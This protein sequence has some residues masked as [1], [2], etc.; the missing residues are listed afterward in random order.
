MIFVCDNSKEI[1]K[2]LLLIEAGDKIYF[3]ELQGD[4]GTREKIEYLQ[5]SLKTLPN[6]SEGRTNKDGSFW[7]YF[8]F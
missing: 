2:A 1:N 4:P 6:G 5:Q 3:R 8:R 7:L